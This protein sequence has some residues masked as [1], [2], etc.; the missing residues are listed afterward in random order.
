MSRLAQR[1]TYRLEGDR[2]VLKK[3]ELGV[4]V[5]VMRRKD[6]TELGREEMGMTYKAHLLAHSSL[7]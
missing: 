1:K 2:L 5:K 3:K 6:T 7:W 4:L